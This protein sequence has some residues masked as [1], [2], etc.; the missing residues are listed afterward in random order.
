VRRVA[1]PIIRCT[2]STGLIQ[3][4]SGPW[5]RHLPGKQFAYTSIACAAG[6]RDFARLCAKEH[7]GGADRFQA[8]AQKLIDGI[9]RRCIDAGKVI[10][11]NAGATD[12]SLYDYFDGGTIEAF[13]LGLVDDKA[14][15][16][17]HM[18]AYEH[19]LRIPGER[20]GFA[21]INKGDAYETAEWILLDLRT[22][23]AMHRFGNA[24]G[25]RA[26]VDW[27]TEHASKNFN[28]LPEL[29]NETTAAYGGAI[30]MVGFGPGAYILAVDAIHGQ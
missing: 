11:G 3:R 22:A 30:P 20:R 9:Q 25:A 4:D 29:L 15:F 1:D 28:L 18:E 26:L 24:R 8:G 23:T 13:S 14:L 16:A 5:E 17:S 19:G 12:P 27:V 6:L 21:R 7:L 10:K 2:D